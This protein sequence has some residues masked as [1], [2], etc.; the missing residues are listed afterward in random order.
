LVA[1]EWPDE[2]DEAVLVLNSNGEITDY[3]LYNIGVL[4]QEEFADLISS[5]YTDEDVEAPDN[6]HI[7]FSYDDALSLS[8]KVVEPFNLYQYNSSTG[9]WTDMSDDEAF[10]TQAIENGITVRVVGVIRPNEDTSTTAL[11]E[12][13]AYSPELTERIIDDADDAE[14]VKQQLANPDVD[15]FT[16]QTFE[17]LQSGAT[18]SFDMGELF[19]VDEAALASAFSFDTSAI[20]ASSIVLDLSGVTPGS[21]GIDTSSISIDTSAINDALSADT[22]AQVMA[23]APQLD[24]S[25]ISVELTDEQQ[26]EIATLSSQLVGGFV[27]WW[28]E[29][30]PNDSLTEN[31]DLS[32]DMQEYLASDTAQGYMAQINAISGGAYGEAIQSAVSDYM[33]N[34]YIPYLQSALQS[35]MSQAAQVMAQ[36]MAQQ[37]QAQI[38]TATQ[39]QATELSQEISSQM[40]SQMQSLASSLQS[41]FSVDADAF[42][43]AIHFNMTQ[44]ELVSLMQSYADASNLTYE[45]NLKTLGYAD[46]DNPNEIDIYPNDFDAKQSILSLID[47]YNDD[48]R[49][50]GKDDQVISYSDIMGSVL[51]S[52]TSIVNTISAILIAFVSISL[53]VSSIMIGVITYISVL[54]RKKEI[55]I[56]RALGASKRN[57]ANVFNA[58]TFIEGLLAGVIAI[59]VVL[60][61]ETPVNAWVY[62]TRAVP[63]V[64]QLS[65]QAAAVLILISVLLTVIAG[66][67]PA[68][69]AARKDPVEALRSE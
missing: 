15:V 7:K 41:S 42:T 38:A 1:G 8:Y 14:I 68:S 56:L 33:Q 62:S 58:E 11:T 20:D 25:S 65:P 34:E 66:L 67:I 26:T 48:M 32:A 3:T 13:I 30:H 17:E 59:V 55:G 21:S 4:D 53:V 47:D 45:N 69:S 36:E 49:A 28:Y 12:G 23:G 22:I 29:Q 9:T 60:I 57:V 52:I 2:Y 18:D 43:N 44:D 40:Q 6:S 51:D 50:E 24:L 46:K 35:L 64:M 39:T 27:P 16:G 31:T 63:N 61:A 54:E 5:L 10:M 19:T 37:L